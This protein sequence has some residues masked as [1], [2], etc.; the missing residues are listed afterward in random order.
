MSKNPFKVELKE[1][2]GV[3]RYYYNGIVYSEFSLERNEVSK[4][5]S[6]SAEKIIADVVFGDLKSDLGECYLFFAVNKN[7]EKWR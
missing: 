2:N 4:L 1:D 6:A 5:D 7:D 3:E